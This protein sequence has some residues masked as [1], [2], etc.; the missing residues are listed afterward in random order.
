MKLKNI[1]IKDI[2]YFL[3]GNLRY[4]LFYSNFVFLIRPHILE[5]I[6]LRIK[7]MDKECYNNGQCKLCGCK[8]TA[9]QMCNKSCEG[10]CYPTM[11]SKKKWKKFKVTT[12]YYEKDTKIYWKLQDNKFII[13]NRY[14]RS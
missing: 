6:E 13:L 5:Q 7:S 9:L 11:I 4:R 10:N 8:T 2:Y 3:Q 12:K 14:G 1:K